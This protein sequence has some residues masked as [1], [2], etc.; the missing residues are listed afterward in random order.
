M[1]SEIQS[2]SST[3]NRHW[4]RGRGTAVRRKIEISTGITRWT[5]RTFWVVDQLAPFVMGTG[6]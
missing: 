5:V 2:T 3:G 4:P 6:S 1:S